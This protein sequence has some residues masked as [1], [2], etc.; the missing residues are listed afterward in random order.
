ML[1]IAPFPDIDACEV[2]EA[3]AP[4]PIAWMRERGGDWQK[5]NLPKFIDVPGE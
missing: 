2:N 1:G 5:L 4:V 3:F